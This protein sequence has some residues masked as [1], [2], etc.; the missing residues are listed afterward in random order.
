MAD[1][2]FLTAQEVVEKLRVSLP[3]VIREIKRGKLR[4]V[5]IGN[6]W[7]VRTEDLE[8]YIESQYEDKRAV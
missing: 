5:K 8:S 3:T 4:G 1:I 7:R 2:E 6:Q